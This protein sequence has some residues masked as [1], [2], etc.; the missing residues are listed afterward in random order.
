MKL[1][2]W[3]NFESLSKVELE[4]IPIGW[5]Y[6]WTH[7]CGGGSFYQDKVEDLYKK[8]D[9]PTEF[10]FFLYLKKYDK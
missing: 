9:L 4:R 1:V 2:K 8:Y 3:E 5:V 10:N 6:D 7:V